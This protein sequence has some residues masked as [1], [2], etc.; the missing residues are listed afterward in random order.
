M[1]HGHIFCRSR[2]REAERHMKVIA[3]GCGNYYQEQKEKL[4]SFGEIEIAAFTDNNPSLWNKAVDGIKVIPPHSI[5]TVEHDK[6]MIVSTYVCA[7]YEQLLA[8]GVEENRV[9]V[10]ERHFKESLKDDMRVL[11][12]VNNKGMGKKV[13]IIS[14]EL[15]Y[16]G[17]AMA[18]VYAAMAVNGMGMAAVLCIPGGNKKLIDE[19]YRQGITVAICPALPY[20][21]ES[22]KE[23]IRQFDAVIVN[24]LTMAESAY[25]ISRIR[26][27]LWWI[28]EVRSIYGPVM[29]SNTAFMHTREISKIN[30]YAVSGIACRNFNSMIGGCAQKMLT[31]GI[32]DKARAC[33]TERKNKKMIFAIVGSIERRKAQD[34]FVEAA[35][36]TDREEESE[37]WIIGRQFDADYSRKIKEMA[38]DNDAVKI[39]GELTREEIDALYPGIDVIVCASHEE[40]LSITVIEGMM[41]GKACITTENTGIAEYIENGINGFVIPCND[42]AMLAEKMRRLIDNKDKL[43]DIG[44]NARKTYEK[45][46]TMETFGENLEKALEETKA[47]WENGHGI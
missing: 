17:G 2:I 7:I 1:L 15:T 14:Q 37:L 3:F 39:L 24:L 20:I 33:R 29:R 25:E 22:R 44:A 5:P 13:L 40:T 23:W 35:K 46:F 30:I 19:V 34:L 42:A 45:Y 31:L 12:A 18:A 41:H 21:F 6:I 36:M 26:P 38:K 11:E 9:I 47:E 43:A 32:P 8:M 10:W 27:T 28:H 4:R 16:D